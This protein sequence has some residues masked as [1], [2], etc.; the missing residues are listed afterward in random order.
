MK[1]FTTY[2]ELTKADKGF[3]KPKTLKQL[4]SI[5]R[6]RERAVLKRGLMAEIAEDAVTPEEV[7]YWHDEF[8]GTVEDYRAIEDEL[9]ESGEFAEDAL[10][11]LESRAERLFDLWRDSRNELMEV[12]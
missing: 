6:G 9:K 3:Y 10:A 8:F 7:A 12:A 1:H 2:E 11:S 4:K 5:Y